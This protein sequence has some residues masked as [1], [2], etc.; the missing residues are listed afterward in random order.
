[1]FVVGVLRLNKIWDVDNQDVE[2]RHYIL[3]RGM[4]G[5]REESLT[6]QVS[7]LWS[8]PQRNYTLGLNICVLVRRNFPLHRSA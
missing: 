5:V 6:S 4:A 3:S 7:Q 1:M 2:L 8:V